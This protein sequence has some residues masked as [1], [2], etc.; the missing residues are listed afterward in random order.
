MAPSDRRP[1]YS[2]RAQYTTFFSYIAG[3]LGAIVGAA[4][5]LVSIF[6]PGA[7]AQLRGAASDATETP[8]Q[9]SAN[10]RRASQGFCAAIAGYFRAGSQNAELQSELREAKIR[11]AEAD[12]TADENRRLRA[13]LGMAAET[14]PV[15]VTQLTSSTASSTRRF[16]TI[17]AGAA[18]GV[19][20]GMPVRSLQGLIGRVLE[21][22]SSTSR[23]LL[24][25]D[26]ESVVPVRR[27]SDGVPAFAQGRGDG[28]LQIRLI[29]LGLNP[30]K[31]GDVM[32]T[33]GSG[34]LYRPGTAVAAVTAI[35]RDGAVARLLSDPAATDY[36]VVEQIW[37][38]AARPVPAAPEDANPAQ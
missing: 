26:T 12:A 22:A 15:A 11:L 18:S 5:L 36:V 38:P 6:D 28:S 1:G 10:T 30:L 25:T 31:L 35:P 9:A 14:R 21:V 2:R 23:V 32:V 13:L 8:G 7:F 16:A 19:T 4:L 33:S 20:V 3:V 24:V 17:G 37:A 34:G 27:A 29:N